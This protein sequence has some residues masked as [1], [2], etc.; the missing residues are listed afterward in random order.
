MLRAMTERAPFSSECP[1]CGHQRV[2]TALTADELREMLAAG[3]DIEAYCISC[4]TRWLVST[5]ERADIARGL[6]RLA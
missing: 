2:Q 5:E 4:D 3:A 6:E 1:K